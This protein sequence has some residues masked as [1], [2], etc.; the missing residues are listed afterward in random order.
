MG[1]KTWIIKNSPKLLTIAGVVCTGG[2]V[3]FAIKVTPEA[4]LRLDKIIEKKKR[5]AL[6][7]CDGDQEKYELIPAYK[8]WP[9]PLEAVKEVGTLYI[10]TGL[11]LG[12]AAGCFI[13]ANNIN[14]KRTAAATA[15][16]TATEEA[17]RNYRTKVVQ[18]IGEKK[19][20]EV[21]DAIA[22]DKV[23]ENP[24]ECV[25]NKTSGRKYQPVI[26]TGRG[27]SLCF[28]AYSGRYW[29]TNIDSIR[30]TEVKMNNKLMNDMYV[31][32]N[33]VYLELGLPTV[34]MGEDLGWDINTTGMINFDYSSIL[35]D[36]EHGEC[37]CLVISY[38]VGPRFGYSELGRY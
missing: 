14:M 30:R 11:M 33:D 20:A 16:F 32:L 35:A 29:Y 26:I 8:M 37:P 38:R 13:G 28:D 6:A 22:Q 4:K 25:E 21:I 18:Q 31:S 3:A 9:T 17:F 5:E 36:E 7:E 23:N 27:D 2:A 1:F 34:E 10:P 19:A 24:P 12:S 15:A